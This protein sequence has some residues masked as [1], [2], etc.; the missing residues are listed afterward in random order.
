MLSHL[1]GYF[2]TVYSFEPT[3]RTYET[4]K[5]RIENCEITNIYHFQKAIF[6][7]DTLINLNEFPDNYSAWNSIGIP[8]MKNRQGRK[9]TCPPIVQT[10]T[11]EGVSLDSFCQEKGISHIDFLKVDV[12]GAESFVFEGANR[13]L[14]SKAIRFIQF[15]VSKNMLEG[16]NKTAKETFEALTKNGYECHKITSSGE[17]GEQIRDSNSF[18]ENYIAFPLLPVHFFTIVLNGEPFIRYHI[19]VFKQLPFKW[20]WHIVEGVADLKHDTAWCLQRGGQISDEIHNNGRSIDGTSE[21]LDE[22]AQQY[23]DNITVYRKPKGDFWDGKLEMVNA[24]LANIKEECLLWQV[25]V[26][27]LWTV[28]QLCTA[29][30]MFI[31]NPEKTAAFYWCWYFVGEELVIRTRNCYAQN[32]RQEWLRTWR[33]KPGYTWEAH[34]PPILVEPLPEN[35]RRNVATTNPFTHAE[36]EER[37]LVFQHFAYVTSS[38]LQ[39]KEKYYGYRDALAR[40]R[41]KSSPDIA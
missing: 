21:Y 15:E 20:H 7:E 16:L 23:P 35:K 37:N 17:I 10:E 31:G 8:V 39:F 30:H 11:V 12:E 4:L 25:D 41:Q 24:P 14:N 38:Q 2:G 32:P 27:E 28:E 6:S 22:L 1:V 19:E 5:R 33:F 13:L 36:S 29:R 3:T 18:Y 9:L 40:L 34:E 26:D